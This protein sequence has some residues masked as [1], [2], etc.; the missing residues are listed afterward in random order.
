MKEIICVLTIFIVVTVPVFAGPI[1]DIFSDSVFGVKWTDDLETVKRKFPGGKV[2]DDHGYLTYEVRD[3]REVLKTAR[4]DKNKIIFTFN[5]IGTFRGVGVEFPYDGPESFA[6]LLN[7]MNTYFGAHKNNESDVATV[8][9]FWPTD[10]GIKVMLILM[11]EVFGLSFD[12]LM[13]IE[14]V[15]PVEASKEE[16]GF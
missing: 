10:N 12:I 14:R 16:L 9:V 8:D 11:P 3:G 2:K 1:S 4:T 15:V 5:A 6:Q 13:S 7:T